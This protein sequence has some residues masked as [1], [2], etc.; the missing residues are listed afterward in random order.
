MYL[1]IVD[2]SQEDSGRKMKYDEILELGSK[3]SLVIKTTQGKRK[4]AHKM[5]SDSSGS[6]RDWGY[7]RD[8]FEKVIQVM[9]T[10]KLLY[11]DIM[12]SK[13]IVVMNHCSICW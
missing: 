4:D 3:L 9:P 12:Y 13:H 1:R 8:C 11:Y 7:E 6:N 10:K 2:P 5:S